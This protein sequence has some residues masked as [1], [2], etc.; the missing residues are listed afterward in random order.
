MHE[1]D[2]LIGDF[3]DWCHLRKHASSQFQYLATVLELGLLL[4]VYVRSL[5]QAS[6]MMYLYALTYLAPCF[7]ALEPTNYARWISIHG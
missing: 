5:R 2:A 4:F 3:E 1:T 6:F 7:R